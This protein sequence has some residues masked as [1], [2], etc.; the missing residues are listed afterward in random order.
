M[1]TTS[2][3][4][5]KRP[6]TASAERFFALALGLTACASAR[7]GSHSIDG[8]GRLDPVTDLNQARQACESGIAAACVQLGDTSDAERPTWYERGCTGGALDGC[9]KL[10]FQRLVA[11]EVSDARSL[12][13]KAC[14]GGDGLGCANL[15]ALYAD[16]E[17]VDR[18]PNKARGLFERACAANDGFGCASLGAMSWLGEGGE[19]QAIERAIELFKQGCGQGSVIGCTWLGIAYQTGRGIESNPPQARVLYT[20]SCEAGDPAACLQLGRLLQAGARGVERDPAAAKS[21]FAR[22]CQLGSAPGCAFDE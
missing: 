14:E 4:P 9:A 13:E 18:D 16:G 19:E 10:G 3:S 15:G 11:G 7:V 20:K 6:T 1:S 17:G 8:G 22:A 21:F 2:S 12:F 5:K